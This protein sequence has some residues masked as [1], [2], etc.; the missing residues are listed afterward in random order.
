MLL[1]ARISRHTIAS[2]CLKPPSP[3]I[4]V[5]H[6]NGSV[7]IFEVT[8]IHP[9]ENPHRG[10]PARQQEERRA[11]GNP[12]AIVPSWVPTDALPAIRFRV[13]EKCKKALG[14]LVE[15][16]ETLSLASR[17]NPKGFNASS[18]LRASSSA[19]SPGSHR[20]VHPVCGAHPHAAPLPRGADAGRR[21]EIV[22]RRGMK[23]SVEAIDRHKRGKH[24]SRCHRA[25]QG[26]RAGDPRVPSPGRAS[27][28]RTAGAFPAK[29]KRPP[30]GCVCPSLESPPA[31]LL[32]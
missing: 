23:L 13:E 26:T 5:Q 10:S 15:P 18:I 24:V 8:E 12:H 9:D 21:A 32:E 30:I 25:N 29:P 1:L 7:E 20:T 2:D 17:Q 4:R 31:C 6:T 27:L 16:H 11:R 3:D 14:Y 22:T 28:R 19:R